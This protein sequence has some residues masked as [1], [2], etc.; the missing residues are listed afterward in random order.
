MNK[1]VN[2]SPDKHILITGASGLIGKALT[3]HLS[4]HY[5][6]HSLSRHDPGAAFYYDQHQQ[7][8]QLSPEIN[9]HGVINLAGANIADQRW[10]PAR[11]REIVESRTLTTATLCQALSRLPAKPEFLL[12]ASAIGYY[13]DTGDQ[14]ADESSPPADDFLG[15]L[16]QQW[17]R[18][19][20]PASE[21]GIRCVP[22]RFGLV[23]SPEGGVLK[24]FILPL[25]LACVGQ[26][27]KG[28]H[29]MSWISMDDLLLLIEAL[30]RNTSFSGPINCCAPDAVTNRDFMRQLAQAVRRPR[31]PALPAAVVRLM[32]GEMADAAL[33][34]SSRVQS[35]RLHELGVRL[36]YPTLDSALRQLLQDS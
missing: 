12:S 11:K 6:V 14:I 16:S 17:E 15:T 35:S 8:M 36:Q 27:G 30:I 26:L 4:A 22:M 31:L 9:L 1:S 32:F 10:S 23:L 21:A 3:R 34:L 24:N 33:L 2:N 7:R 29:Y 20:Q 28:E 18:A 19:C 13:G 5:T 25:K